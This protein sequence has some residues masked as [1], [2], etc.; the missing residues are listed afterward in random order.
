MIT[1]TT[2]CDI[3]VEVEPGLDNEEALRAEICVAR[4]DLLAEHLGVSVEAVG[5]WRGTSPPDVNH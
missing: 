2:E 5:I 1:S 3:A 4:N